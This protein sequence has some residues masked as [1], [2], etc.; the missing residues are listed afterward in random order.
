RTVPLF[1]SATDAPTVRGN[2][3]GRDPDTPSRRR[4]IPGRAW[5]RLQL[6]APHTW[7]LCHFRP[8]TCQWPAS[9]HRRRPCRAASTRHT[10]PCSDSKFHRTWRPVV[11]RRSSAAR[12]TLL[13]PNPE[14]L[15]GAVQGNRG[16]PDV[17]LAVADT[18][19]RQS[20]P[21]LRKPKAATMAARNAPVRE[22]G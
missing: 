4:T 21:T 3:A 7:D 18:S 20:A 1:P 11:D 8:D 17:P 12:L 14:T 16:P 10:R 13:F 22:P 5:Q 2:P 6:T 19:P 15:P 9:A